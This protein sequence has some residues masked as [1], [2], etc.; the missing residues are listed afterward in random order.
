MSPSTDQIP[1]W[2]TNICYNAPKD[3]RELLERVRKQL[4]AR[5]LG[6]LLKSLIA[7]G[8]EQT[9]QSSAAELREIRKRY[10]GATLALL[11]LAATV[12][13]WSTPEELQRQ[14]RRCVRRAGCRFEECV[15]VET[16]PA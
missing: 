16:E 9:C 6:Q 4:G 14:C 8:M 12:A 2:S 1:G 5:S 11:F 15:T 3:E 10:Y 13:A 7:R